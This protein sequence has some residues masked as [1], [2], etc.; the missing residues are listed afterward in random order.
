MSNKIGIIVLGGHIQGLT[1]IRILGKLGIPSVLIDNTSIN[2]ARYSRYCKTFYKC[3]NEEILSTLEGFRKVNKYKDWAVFPT[4]DFHVE[5]LSKNRENLNKYFK[6]TSDEWSI[7][8]TWFN[9]RESYKFV[10]SL[11]ITIPKTWYCDTLDELNSVDI[12]PCIIKP[13]VMHR[14]YTQVK[15]KVFVCKDKFDLI[16]YFNKAVE[17]IPNDEII[18]QE[19]IPGSSENQYSACFLARKGEILV[20]LSAR[21]ARQHPPDF[22]NA[23][24]FAETTEYLPFLDDARKII[25]ENGYTGLCEVEFKYDSR[26][27][28]YKFLEVNPRTWKWHGIAVKAETPFL[29]QLIN[30]LYDE[31]VNKV[32]EWKPATF[33]HVV[34]DFTVKF[35]MKLNHTYRRKNNIN[36]FNAVWDW[37]DLGPSVMEYIILP[38]LILKR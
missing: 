38:Y 7:L 17:I 11:D 6:V 20:Q 26:D 31:T 37:N 4:N 8:K 27:N 9:K 14:F 32:L 22:G 18:I 25:G 19:I 28:T 24:T 13:A 33:Y 2:L 10:Q 23:T 35:K 3:E 36:A 5:L 15:Q 21:R 29:P 30:F 12:F 34:T 16:D 1:I